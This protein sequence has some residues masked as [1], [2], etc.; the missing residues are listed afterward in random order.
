MS[1]AKELC[2]VMHKPA[3]N[4]IWLIE[5]LA[6]SVVTGMCFPVSVPLDLVSFYFQAET[7]DYVIIESLK[8][9]SETSI[10]SHCELCDAKLWISNF[11]SGECVSVNLQEYGPVPA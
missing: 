5:M 1:A 10:F 3:P 9:K 4:A 6:F 11:I 8:V 7:L 2:L